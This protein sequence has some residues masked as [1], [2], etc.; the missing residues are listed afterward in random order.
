MH[1]IEHFPE[2][3]VGAG[4]V[5]FYL[6]GFLKLFLRL[7]ITALGV[8]GDA[9]LIVVLRMGWGPF[10]CLA[11]SVLGLGKLTAGLKCSAGVKG[12]C[13]FVSLLQIL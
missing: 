11:I 3:Y 9:Q 4:V 5:W 13:T 12:L 1:V 6:Q 10:E 7:G 2:G 8:Q